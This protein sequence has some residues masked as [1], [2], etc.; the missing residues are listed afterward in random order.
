MGTTP[1][2]ASYPGYD[3]SVIELPAQEVTAAPSDPWWKLRAE[4]IYSAI[5]SGNLR[6]HDG[7][8]DAQYVVHLE[9][10]G[11]LDLPGGQLVAGDPYVMDDEPE[12][13]AQTLAADTVDVLVARALVGKDHE[14]NAALILHVA[15]SGPIS[16]WLMATVS[17]QD[18]ATL[19]QESFFGYG[20]DAG[21]GSFG[22]REAMKVAQ[23]VLSADA[24]MLEDPVSTALFS[25]G[26]AT[27]SAIVLAP[28]A[29]A[30]PVAVCSSG[31]GDGSYP[32]W[33]GVDASGNVIVAVTDF[34]LTG[35]PHAAS[36]PPPHSADQPVPRT[37]PK[38]LLRRL[39]GR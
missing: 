19:E 26:L 29:G 30:A 25:D 4:W 17:D 39:L 16:G 35:D 11:R 37:P 3:A 31:W 8:D 2:H 18:P 12:A 36:L 38:S 28:E 1:T 13:F 6:D 23:R 27:R 20:V 10:I 7:E 22:S 5:T 32:T 21:T 34:L 33:L 24:G 15:G 9:V 14:R